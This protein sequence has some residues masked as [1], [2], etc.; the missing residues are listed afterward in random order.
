M[1]TYNV[2]KTEKNEN[3]NLSAIIKYDKKFYKI[4][5]CGYCPFINFIAEVA[6]CDLTDKCIYVD[7]WNEIEKDCPLFT[8]K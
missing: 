6:D 7:M 1:I 2:L 3:S 4:D 8:D 5:C